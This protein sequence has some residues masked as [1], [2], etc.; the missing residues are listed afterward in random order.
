METG[1]GTQGQEIQTC[2][3]EA[4]KECIG[5]GTGGSWWDGGEWNLERDYPEDAVGAPV[6]ARL[7]FRGEHGEASQGTKDISSIWQVKQQGE[8]GQWDLISVNV[9]KGK[10]QK[11]GKIQNTRRQGRLAKMPIVVK[12]SEDTGGLSRRVWTL[13]QQTP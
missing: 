7:Q 6:W 13:H 1:Q 3:R 5:F 2:A 12:A 4:E 8:R 10:I 9:V 11:E